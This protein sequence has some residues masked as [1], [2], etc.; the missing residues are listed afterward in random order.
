MSIATASAIL[1]VIAPE[2]A[3]DVKKADHLSLAE[4][5][6]DTTKFGDKYN[7]A[8]ALRAAH[9]LTIANQTTGAASG[10][11]KSRK[12]GDLSISYGTIKGVNGYL[13]QT[14]YGIELLGLIR[15]NI[16][17]YSITG[18]TILT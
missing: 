8:V 3:S 5:R 1:D 11:V 6:T 10:A 15:G 13:S 9:T 7:Y 12:E 2:L 17:A 18:S 14:S 4:L 16:P